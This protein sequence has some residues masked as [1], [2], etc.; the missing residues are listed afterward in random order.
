[1]VMNDII[2]IKSELLCWG[3]KLN[4]IAKKAIR[5]DYPFVFNDKY[6]H[7]AH[8][9]LNE[10]TNVN[11]PI[12]ER[13][14]DR[15]P[16]EIEY[17]GKNMMLSKNGKLLMPIEIIRRP[18]WY[19]FKLDQNIF[20]HDI[21]QVHGTTTLV[22][23]EYMCCDYYKEGHGCLFCS[24]PMNKSVD[25][26]NLSY[27][28]RTLECAT[29]ENPRYSITLSGGCKKSHDHGSKFFVDIIKTIKKIDDNIPISVELAPP[30]E[31][32]YITELIDLGVSALIMNIEFYDFKIRS[33]LCPEKSKIKVER[34]F[35]ALDYSVSCLG[36]GNASSVLIVGLE[37]LNLTKEC[38]D[39]LIEMGVI[40]TLIPFRPYDNCYLSNFTTTN[41]ICLTEAAE[42][43]GKKLLKA[44]LHPKNQRGCT[45]CGGCSLEIDFEKYLNNIGVY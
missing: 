20:M 33:L 19:N 29:A 17:D 12:A 34:Y 42:Y 14:C 40:P 5:S 35:Q 37:D 6:V 45:E 38:A 2:N 25:K 4:E 30:D 21:F 8:F 22:N 39:I 24:F 1:M 18:D 7:G 23:S 27:I 13:F 44:N 43:V 16:Y 15:S 41:P 31:N 36:K 3:I 28:S 10:N 26:I 32:F 9:I 11:V